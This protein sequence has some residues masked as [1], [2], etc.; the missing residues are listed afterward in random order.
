MNECSHATK[1]HDE[2]CDLVV[3]LGKDLKEA[4][5]LVLELFHQECLVSPVPKE[6]PR[7]YDHMHRGTYEE[8]QEA[9]LRW[10]LI[11]PEECLRK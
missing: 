7:T 5:E 9:L 1:R 10:G 2:E 8:A 4:R 11:K 3:G 6:D